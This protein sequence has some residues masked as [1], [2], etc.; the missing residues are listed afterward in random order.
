MLKLATSNGKTYTILSRQEF[1]MLTK[2]LPKDVADDT[3]I[4]LS[5]LQ[6]ILATGVTQ[7]ALFSDLQNKLQAATTALTALKQAQV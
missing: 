4:D 7:A 6:P 3:E 5:W 1:L 2:L